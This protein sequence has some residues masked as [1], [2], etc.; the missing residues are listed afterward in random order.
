MGKDSVGKGEAKLAHKTEGENGK[1]W[2]KTGPE[3][4]GYA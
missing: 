2:S 3:N 4:E 1:N